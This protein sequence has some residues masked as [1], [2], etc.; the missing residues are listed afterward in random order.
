ML[1]LL[2][3][4]FVVVVVVVVA[5]VVV[6]TETH[7]FSCCSTESV[8]GEVKGEKEKEKRQTKGRVRCLRCNRRKKGDARQVTQGLSLFFFSLLH[9]RLVKGQSQEKRV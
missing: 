7:E 5:V 6:I 3:L 8:E 4:F 2:L 9:L 1:F